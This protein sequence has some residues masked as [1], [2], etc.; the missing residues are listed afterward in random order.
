MT[1][2]STPSRRPLWRR[3]VAFFDPA[4]PGFG[5]RALIGLALALVLVGCGAVGVATS[6]TQFA[7][8]RYYLGAWL[9]ENGFIDQAESMAQ[10]LV[11]DHPRESSA[12]YLLL[13]TV[14]RRTG[15]QAEQLAVLDEA[16]AALPE[17]GSAHSDR[18]WYGSLFGSAQRV[19]ASCDKAVAMTPE[20][21]G[22]AHARRA[23]ARLRVG[24]HAG[25]EADLVEAIR[26]WETYGT[27]PRWILRSRRE[28]L[29]A[30]RAGKDPLDEATLTFE[31]ER[32]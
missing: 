30:I 5:R 12:Y 29:A 6:L 31:R 18:C 4:E 2:T 14:Y 19:M 27:A 25:A 23:F 8:P 1:L 3:V 15:R 10:G 24:D 16:V 13:A 9:L 11:R 28:W 32:F 7:L 21:G 20:E 22:F 17:S 26:R